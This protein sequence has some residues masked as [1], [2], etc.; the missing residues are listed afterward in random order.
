MKKHFLNILGLI[1][2]S[3]LLIWSIWQHELIVGGYIWSS[4]E[5]YNATFQWFSVPVLKTT[6]GQAYDLTLL[7]TFIAYILGLLSLWFWED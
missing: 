7:C 3:A 5:V 1:F 4:P 6:I 2:A